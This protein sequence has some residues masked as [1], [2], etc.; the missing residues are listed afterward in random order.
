MKDITPMF[1][2]NLRD[3]KLDIESCDDNDRKDLSLRYEQGVVHR[4]RVHK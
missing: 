4:D 1:K 2:A 3:G